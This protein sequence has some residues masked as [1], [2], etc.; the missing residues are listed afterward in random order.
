M[1]GLLF[2]LDDTVL[3]HGALCPRALSAMFALRH[4]GLELIAVT[5]RP[6]AWGQVLLR[7][8]PLAGV[9]TE[10]GPISVRYEQSRVVLCDRL[11]TS[12]RRECGDQLDA[13]VAQIQERWPQVLASDDCIGRVADRALD[14]AETAN[15]DEQTVRQ[16]A[17]FART[18]GARV[19]R[20]S[21]HLHLTFDADDKATGALRFLKD[22]LRIDPTLAR[23][24]YAFV[25][26]SQND[27]PCF[28]GFEHTFG[29]ANLLGR[30]SRPPKYVTASERSLG[31]TELADRLTKLRD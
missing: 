20:S 8:W 3:D 1:R 31:F 2:D 26:D 4:V 10:N 21:I 24:R 14:I 19:T 11:T 16:I 29:V 25:G 12:Q 17:G 28:A 27:A 9:V 22:T 13:V 5:G 18:R 6:A 23:Y 7:Q 30:F 15:V